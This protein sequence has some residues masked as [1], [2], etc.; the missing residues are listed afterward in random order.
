[1]VELR[2]KLAGVGVF[3]L[4]KEIRRCFGR[5]LVIIPNYRAAVFFP[6]GT[7]YEDVLKSLEVIKADLQHRA[8][9]ERKRGK[10]R[11]AKTGSPI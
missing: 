6:E 9:C 4:P 8:E 1:M 11:K 10:S 5:R 3:Y 7:S 2:V